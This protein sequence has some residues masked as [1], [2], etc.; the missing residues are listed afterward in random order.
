M[1]L[2]SKS[3]FA[4]QLKLCRRLAKMSQEDL[5][6][7]A[8]L[9][10]GSSISQYEN[11]SILP[12]QERLDAIV[13]AFR[14]NN[15]P[16]EYLEKL[17]I[18]SG[19]S[20]PQFS[21]HTSE[22]VN[23]ILEGPHQETR[24]LL[25]LTLEKVLMQLEKYQMG[26]TKMRRGENKEAQEIFDKLLKTTLNP[27]L[28]KDRLHLKLLVSSADARRLQ[29]EL[30]SAIEILK[31]AE[32]IARSLKEEGLDELANLLKLRGNI[33]RRLSKWK[34]A[35]N[36]FND[37]IQA[38]REYEY[39]ANLKQ[40][41][42]L[43]NLERKLAGT[44]LF[45]GQP[46]DAIMHITRSITI[47]DELSDER[48]KI[49]GLQHHAWAVALLGFL[50]KALNIHKRIVKN[51][52][53]SKTH[54]ITL[55]KS[56]RYLGDSYRMCGMPEKAISE[57][58]KAISHLDK[59][60]KG[61]SED[62]D[63]LVYGTIDLGIGA[64][65]RALKNLNEAE[66]HLNQSIKLHMK[67]GARYYEALSRRELG[68]LMSDIG[69]FDRAKSEFDKA[70]N[71]FSDLENSYYLAGI[72]RD[73][74]DLEYKR[75]KFP[76]ARAYAT[77]AINQ[78]NE[79]E[80]LSRLVTAQL[81]MAKINFASPDKLNPFELYISA[82]Q[83]ALDIDPYLTYEILCYISG[84]PYLIKNEHALKSETLKLC[85]IILCKKDEFLNLTSFPKNSILTWFENVDNLRNQ[86]QN[87]ISTNEFTNGR[88][89]IVGV[90]DYRNMRTL[91]KTIID[92]QDLRDLLINRGYPLSNISL[93]IDS[94]ATKKNISFALEK[95]TCEA[96]ITDTVLFFFSGH[97][98][99]SV[100]GFEPGE[101]ICPV[102]VDSGDLKRTAISN[103]EL[104]TAIKSIP[105]KQVIVLLDACHSGGVGEPKN[106]ETGIKTGLTINT[107]ERLATGE[108][109]VVIASCKPNEYSWELPNMR[110]GLFSHYLLKGLE[111]DSADNHGAVRIFQLFNYVSE[112]VP[113]HKP[114]HPLLKVTTDRDFPVIIPKHIN[115]QNS[116]DNF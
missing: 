65:Y 53:V 89:V 23:E 112:N 12:P 100:G 47:Y 82:L 103:D 92:A 7:A 26:L 74:A 110:N 76:E 99:R 72:S 29:G 45:E 114:Q 69:D 111:G 81:S 4:Q 70:Q 64:S 51:F 83:N 3:L 58:E 2:N 10:G 50:D 8:K 67:M 36:D 71:I 19:Y 73:F 96:K 37:S 68:K 48:G 35:K 60:F 40:D 46:K 17:Y 31:E 108:G 56:Y 41:S 107:Y 22:R 78:A 109:R 59:F 97:G 24:W 11:A 94:Q 75:K 28:Y 21:N 102:D 93:L 42:V 30:I 52:D 105:A 90:G 87:E 88:A 95:L 63:V 27:L 9:G 43:A 116:E 57:Y 6:F 66:K 18:Y 14:D 98:A 15:V 5:A 20:E 1:E 49:Q 91:E 13:S 44:H 106:L 38:F 32:K 25:Q 16:D 39:Y 54:P 86:L 80:F 77:K 113:K 33:Y 55:A 61:K 115:S 104:T 84:Q 62:K 79:F 85:E 34:E 101:Y